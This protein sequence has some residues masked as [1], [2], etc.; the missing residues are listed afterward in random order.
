MILQNMKSLFLDNFKFWTEFLRLNVQQTLIHLKHTCLKFQQMYFDLIWFWYV[1]CCV[2]VMFLNVCGS[3]QVK[4]VSDFQVK[5]IFAVLLV[6]TTHLRNLCFYSFNIFFWFHDCGPLYFIDSTKC[7][8]H[9][10]RPCF[11]MQHRLSRWL[12]W[13]RHRLLQ[14]TR[15]TDSEKRLKLAFLL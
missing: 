8:I 11:K 9:L 13:A 10:L 7:C 4:M 3:F 6:M 1:E 14:D 15:A 12:D 2:T 5:H